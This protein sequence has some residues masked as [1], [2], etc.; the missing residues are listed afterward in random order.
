MFLQL[1]LER[2]DEA[3][4]FGRSLSSTHNQS[5]K[6]WSP[7]LVSRSC[8]GGGSLQEFRLFGSSPS[9]LAE[10][11]CICRRVRLTAIRL[12]IV[13]HPTTP[14]T[15]STS[16]SLLR[17]YAGPNTHP[18]PNKHSKIFGPGRDSRDVPLCNQPSCSDPKFRRP[19]RTAVWFPNDDGAAF[20]NTNTLRPLKHR[21][22]RP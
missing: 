20:A 14:I 3:C 5:L 15:T 21:D 16:G 1:P 17:R 7:F 9:T 13:Y 18:G 8:S 19:P 11:R 22:P 6:L 12:N 10:A 2:D 4:L